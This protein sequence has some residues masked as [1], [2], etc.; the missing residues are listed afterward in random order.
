MK[1]VSV[2][3]AIKFGF[4]SLIKKPLFFI[5]AYLMTLLIGTI[6]VILAFLI[7]MPFAYPLIRMF[8][9]LRIE[10]MGIFGQALAKAMMLGTTTPETIQAG[11][12][13]QMGAGQLKGFILDVIR[14][15]LG[16]FWSHPGVFLL[17]GLTVLIIFCMYIGIGFYIYAGW[18]RITLDFYDRGS[19][20]ISSLF[21]NFSTLI[22][23]IVS[24]FIYGFLIVLPWKIGALL[25]L[26]FPNLILLFI[27]IPTAIFFSS[28]F[29]LRFFYFLYFIVEK[30]DGI[31]E[32]LGNAYR[33]KGAAFRL[34]LL[35]FFYVLIAIPLFI[36]ISFIPQSWSFLSLIFNII[37]GFAAM[38][39]GY[40]AL[41][42]LYKKLSSV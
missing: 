41:G 12:V 21:S 38:V 6:G 36:I 24:G 9:R 23:L 14:G 7:T 22:K 29:F 27:L 5:G 42:F 32:C 19:S 35:W 25:M 37:Y 8:V 18:A 33:L 1:K 4:N 39:I 26:F 28:F 3:E 17:L 31:L 40:M 11:A 34:I 10:I 2:I 15:I 13:P 16:F 20:A 30:N